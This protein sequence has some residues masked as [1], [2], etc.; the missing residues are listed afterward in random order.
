MTN[1]K[2]SVVFAAE[3]R[4]EILAGARILA[5]AVCSTMGP[6]G[7][8][9]II[10]HDGPPYITKDGVTVAKSIFLKDRLQAVGADLL[11]E[12]ASKTNETAGDGTTSSTALAFSILENGI[13][14]ITTGRSAIQLKKG[15]DLGVA[16]VLDDLKKY[17]RKIETETQVAQIGTISANG[18]SE[19]GEIIAKAVGKVGPDGIITV[20][21]ARSVQTELEITDGLKLDS[22]FV[23]P[24]F[25][26]NGE[27]NTCVLED[28]YILLTTHN[29]NTIKEIVPILEKVLHTNKP[30]LIVAENCEGEALHTIIANKM[31]G[32]LKACVVKA[33]SY[34]EFRID[35]L[36]DLVTLVGGEIIGTGSTTSLQN[37]S[38]EQLG[39]AKTVTVSK[40]DT[41]LVGHNDRKEVVNERIASLRELLSSPTLDELQAEKLRQRLAKLSGGVAVLKIGG[42]TETEI[43]EKK[44]RAV[45]AVNATV[46]GV[47]EGIVP[48]GGAAL[49]YASEDLRLLKK[50]LVGTDEL[51]D[52]TLA[53]I[54]IV[55][56]ACQAPL[57]QIVTNTGRSFDVVANDIRSRIK[58]VDLSKPQKK[59]LTVEQLLAIKD[60]RLIGRD[61]G[62]NALT[63]KYENLL[64][65]GIIDPVKVT[66]CALEYAASIVGLMLTCNAVVLTREEE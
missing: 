66:R 7:H 26:T 41:V 65:T 37:V 9:V 31:K 59:E 50:S 10:D 20:E 25:V 5:R 29:V 63:H 6:S 55:V 27:K 30:L 54:D 11:K 14:Q 53:G 35:I 15:I 62:Y 28:P 38:L 36:N 58:K 34:G 49:F 52:D 4:N 21:K 24:Y 51:D 1:K 19:L 23:S 33:P 56:E 48:G 32:N 44:D 45:D 57:R 61:W 60:D 64:E 8:N 13:K 16:H 2:E 22:G 17:C 42:S 3:A 47:Q 18:D 43:N 40:L 12:V 39:R 46:A